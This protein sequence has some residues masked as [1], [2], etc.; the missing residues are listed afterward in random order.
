MGIKKL[1]AKE[2]E[3][4]A[5]IASLKTIKDEANIKLQALNTEVQVLRSEY[6][7]DLRGPILSV[8]EGVDHDIWGI[9]MYGDVFHAK[10][11]VSI[12]PDKLQKGMEMGNM[13]Y[14]MKCA[15]MEVN[16]RKERLDD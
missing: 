16:R 9:T 1:R 4:L 6:I 14:T 10:P 8:M 3:L 15:Y 11:S 13:Y 12:D 2:Y 5:N 7:A